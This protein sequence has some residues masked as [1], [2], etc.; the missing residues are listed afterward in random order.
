MN[1]FENYPLKQQ[2]LI[3]T[4]N[5]A[6]IE[7]YIHDFI[8]N[9]YAKF[10]PF[11]NQASQYRES[12]IYPL[13]N[14][15]S[16]MDFI[17]SI[18]GNVTAYLCP[19]EFENLVPLHIASPYKLY[20]TLTDFFKYIKDNKKLIEINLDGE[21]TPQVVLDFSFL[22]EDLEEM[23]DY[24]IGKFND[25]AGPVPLLEMRSCLVNG[26]VNRFFDLMGSV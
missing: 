2:N 12:Y 7:K 1:Q 14:A 5:M 23:L 10:K 16:F 15:T 17:I 11:Y 4:E 8:G 18:D 26:N 20:I 6:F 3:S 22:V 21:N 19:A 24:L 13:E 25:F 9:W